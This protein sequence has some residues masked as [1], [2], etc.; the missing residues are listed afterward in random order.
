MDRAEWLK[1]RAE[2]WDEINKR[3][4][5]LIEAERTRDKAY[6]SSFNEN[7]VYLLLSKSR[8]SSKDPA[9]EYAESR[10]DGAVY[11]LDAALRAAMIYIDIDSIAA[12]TAERLELALSPLVWRAIEE[13]VKRDK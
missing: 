8:R 9:Q 2:E 1:L 13:Q 11:D 3:M 6:L 10:I 5:K 4:D 7:T 12:F